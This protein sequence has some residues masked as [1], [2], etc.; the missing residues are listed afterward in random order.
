MDH[1]QKQVKPAWIKGYSPIHKN[2]LLLLIKGSGNRTAL[3]PIVRKADRP[4]GLSL[5]T[6]LTGAVAAPGLRPPLGFL[7]IN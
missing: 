5:G 3:P 7:S 6:S 2:K 1:T 4:A